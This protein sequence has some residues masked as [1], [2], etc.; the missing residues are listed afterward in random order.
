M[1]SIMCFQVIML[2]EVMCFQVMMLS[3]CFQAMMLSMF[4]GND[5]VSKMCLGMMTLSIVYF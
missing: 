1:L 2:S 3:M 4:S 5:A